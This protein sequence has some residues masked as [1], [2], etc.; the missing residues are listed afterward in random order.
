M[1]RKTLRNFIL[2]GC[3]F[4]AFVIFTIVV[5]VVDVRPVGAIGS[6]V[7]LSSL[8]QWF[9]NLLGINSIFDV[10]TDILGVLVILIALVYVGIGILQL[11]KRKSIKKIDKELQLL[12]IVYFLMAAFY[13][14][15]EIMIINYR[16]ILVG[17][18]LAASYP[19]SHVLLTIVIVGT[20]AIIINKRESR[21]NIKVASSVAAVILSI[22]SVAGRLLAGVHWLTDVIAGALLA[23]SIVMLYFTC[24]NYEKKEVVED[25][26]G[27]M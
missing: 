8:N 18:E 14:L 13:I 20:T 9:F 1:N 15:F 24:L 26:E 19:S 16:P 2:T 3:L 23:S 27:T 22:A 11:F 12:A 7:G 17:G 25:V 10:I 21:K 4:L 5:K 6:R